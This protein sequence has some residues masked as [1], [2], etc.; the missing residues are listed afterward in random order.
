MFFRGSEHNPPHLHAIYGEYLGIFDI[1]NGEL[2][3]GDLPKN[4]RRLV[5]EWI[6]LHSDEL[7]NI[8]ETQDFRHIE[9]LD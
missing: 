4:A 2:L 7:L 8:W 3:A 6:K 1:K 9:P 5:Q